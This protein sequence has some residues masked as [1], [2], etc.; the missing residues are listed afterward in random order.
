MSVSCY[1]FNL[2]KKDEI[3]GDF[4]D[5]TISQW[6]NIF[7]KAIIGFAIANFMVAMILAIPFIIIAFMIF[8]Y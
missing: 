1:Y 2:L 5:Y 6:S 8:P 3:Y 4:R 7:A